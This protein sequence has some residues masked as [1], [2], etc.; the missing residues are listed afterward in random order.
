[1]HK[2]ISIIITVDNT[3]ESDLSIPLSSINNQIGFD[4][5]QLEVLVV[6]NGAYKL[7]NAELFSIFANLDLKY[8][9][10][11]QVLATSKALQYGIDHATGDYV[12]LM[13]PN[14]QLNQSSIFQ[15]YVTQLQ[16]HQTSDVLSGLV[17]EQTITQQ[18]EE[19]Y[20]VGRNDQSIYARWFR[21]EFLR[22][23]GITFREDFGDYA[24]EYVCR[25][26]NQFAQ[27]D[28]KIEEVGYVKF[29][30]RNLVNNAHLDGSGSI[31]GD[32]LKMMSSYLLKLQEVDQQLYVN[33]FSQFVVRFYTQLKQV[34]RMNRA[35]I[36]QSLKSLVGK[37]VLAWG[38]TQQFINNLRIQDRSPQAPWNA[39]SGKFFSYVNELTQYLQSYGLAVKP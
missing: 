30:S 4:F 8:L 12:T 36:M 13:S 11:D 15:S 33:E 23:N 26:A 16:A 28:V 14:S 29:S 3:Q 10:L 32:W 17:M 9:K 5:S 25:L 1:M 6:D 39:E 27:E 31:N 2:L 21:R 34:P 35:E 18:L 19:Q 37:N 7:R 20:T 38:Y 22:Q 24:P